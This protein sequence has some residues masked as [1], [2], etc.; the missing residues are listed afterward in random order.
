M[1][2]PNRIGKIERMHQ[3]SRCCTKSQCSPLGSG[4]SH[5]EIL[6]ESIIERRHVSKTDISRYPLISII[7]GL[8]H[9]DRT[10]QTETI[11]ILMQVFPGICLENNMEITH[12][13]GREPGKFIYTDL[14]VKHIRRLKTP[15][16]F[17]Y[18]INTMQDGINLRT[19]WFIL[20]SH[21]NVYLPF[22][23]ILLEFLLYKKVVP[24]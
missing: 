24:L 2:F 7:T 4:R 23:Q 8:E 18:Q 10:L 1:N 14:S 6:L 19:V 20:G 5:S 9:P 3:D 12:R 11:N 22:L 13:H 16:L 17:H 21:I 15:V